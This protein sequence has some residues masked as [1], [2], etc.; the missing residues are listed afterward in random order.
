MGKK[1]E[2]KGILVEYGKVTPDGTVYMSGCFGDSLNNFNQKEV[3]HES[4]EISLQEVSMLPGGGHGIGF[5][6]KSKE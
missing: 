2:Q 1:A 5:T 4:K 3:T 6:I